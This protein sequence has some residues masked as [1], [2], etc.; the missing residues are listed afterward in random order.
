MNQ[1][2]CAKSSAVSSTHRISTVDKSTRGNLT[3]TVSDLVDFLSN[4]LRMKIYTE[5][6]KRNKFM[7]V[8]VDKMDY[9]ELSEAD[10]C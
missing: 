4:M 1:S 9:A 10:I 7:R 6:S 3:Q 5:E 8:R 2:V